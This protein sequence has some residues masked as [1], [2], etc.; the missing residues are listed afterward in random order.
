MHKNNL[1]IH[2][3]IPSYS[4]KLLS[5]FS[6]ID[7]KTR[8]L[9]YKNQDRQWK[10]S[11]MM[12]DLPYDSTNPLGVI[13]NQLPLYGS[14]LWKSMSES[15]RTEYVYHYQLSGISRTLHGEACG[16]II[17]GKLISMLPT[18]DSR[19]VASV[20]LADEYRH[21]E[22]ISR[23]MTER[24]TD[25]Y[26]IRP[27]FKNIIDNAISIGA[28]DEC[29]LVLAVL[30]ICASLQFT[31]LQKLSNNDFFTLLFDK[32]S[33]DEARHQAFAKLLL[34]N[35]YKELSYAEILH[36]EE[37]LVNTIH[38]IEIMT[39]QDDLRK[40]L[41]LSKELFNE[42]HEPRYRETI[43]AILKYI[44]IWLSGTGLSMDR[45]RARFI[46]ETIFVG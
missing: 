8:N 42:A 46:N 38:Q 30:D 37:L 40:N 19:F 15:A 31:H 43:E 36:K 24:Y 6:I 5:D 32:I 13:E 23:V 25:I 22:I 33:Q 2:I 16:T 12:W 9:F 20:Q 27:E 29:Y 7:E 44:G 26:P 41:N 3:G 17:L 4:I 28:W 11:D 35:Y 18:Y 45:I 10:S 1:D 34:Q 14:K 21:T 39:R